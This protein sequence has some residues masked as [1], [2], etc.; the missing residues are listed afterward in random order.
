MNKLLHFCHT[1]RKKHDLVG[2][3]SVDN[4]TK[5]CDMEAFEKDHIYNS[6]TVQKTCISLI[7]IINLPFT[8][9][10]VHLLFLSHFVL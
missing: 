2:R 8:S 4:N 5:R 6:C 10:A 9:D 7:Y 3:K 1:A